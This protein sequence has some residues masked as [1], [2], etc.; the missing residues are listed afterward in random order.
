[1]LYSYPG[2]VSYP[3]NYALHYRENQ[4]QFSFLLKITALVKKITE[5]QKNQSQRYQNSKEKV[6]VGFCYG[7]QRPCNK[8][9]PKVPVGYELGRNPLMESANLH[10]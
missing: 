2:T 4:T 8:S 5:G 6:L 10:L 1:M 7:K 9:N 3:Y